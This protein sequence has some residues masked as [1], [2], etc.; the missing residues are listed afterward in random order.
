M[1]DFF[2]LF[3]APRRPWLDPE[4]LKQ[5]YHQLT[6]AAHPDVRA[7]EESA[8][9]KEINEAYRVLLDPKQRI[10]HLLALENGAPA[11]TNRTVPADLQELFPRVG[12]VAQKSRA[13]LEQIGNA[14]GALSR[15]LLKT[16]LVNLQLQTGELLNELASSYEDCLTEL[17]KLNEI[18]NNDKMQAIERLKMLYDDISYLTRWIAQ[19]EEAQFQLSLS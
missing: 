17:R 2:A 5:K 3:Q 15:S 13:V 18:W 1:T 19:L 7:R 12:A 16:D 11:A 9:F 8:L 4:V 14:T 10:Q 6:R